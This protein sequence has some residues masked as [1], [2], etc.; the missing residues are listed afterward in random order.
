MPG[1]RR[2]ADTGDLP[3]ALAIFPLPG[4]LLLPRGRLPLNIFEPRYLQMIDDALAGSRLIGMIQPMPGQ[5]RV[6]LPDTYRIGC[7]G[8][9]TS[10]QETADG[11]YMISLTGICR[12]RVEAEL[13]TVTPYRQVAPLWDPFASDLIE[14]DEDPS[15]DRVSLEASLRTY[16]EKTGM[17]ADWG[18]IEKAPLETLVNSL[19]MICPF[20][21]PEKQALLEA[22]GLADRAITLKTCI[23]MASLERYGGGQGAPVQ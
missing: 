20:D 7:A 15:I 13:Q 2:Y 17:R 5:D 8:R 12:F 21:A 9:L 16:F 6:K 11:R 18:S 10:L 4:A 23:E 22:P 1:P 14:S 19:S 3:A